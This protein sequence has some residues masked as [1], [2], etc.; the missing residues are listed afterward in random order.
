[1]IRFANGMKTLQFQDDC[2]KAGMLPSELRRLDEFPD[3]LR[4]W[5]SGFATDEWMVGRS[6]YA[7][8]KKFKSGYTPILVQLR[9][10]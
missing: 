8:E 6:R 7:A 5:M 2:L 9:K 3:G 10:V 4:G 1:M